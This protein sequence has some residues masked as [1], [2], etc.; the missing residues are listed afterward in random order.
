MPHIH[1]QTTG[2]VVENVDIAD[3]LH[4]LTEELAKIESIT[5]ASIKAYHSLHTQWNMG[6]GGAQGFIHCE[7]AI[8][9][10]RPL[11]L[12]QAIGDK[13]KLALDLAFAES[14]ES[15]AAN[16]TIEVREMDRETYKK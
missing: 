8:L 2:N 14:I 3:I 9:S 5:A 12:R 4:S 16:L 11:E 6:E 1:L 13:F 10:G 15:G 7:V